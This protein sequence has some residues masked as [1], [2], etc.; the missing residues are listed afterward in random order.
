MRV[1]VRVRVCLCVCMCLHSYL[2]VCVC[3]RARVCARACIWC[4]CL[5]VGMR[6]CACACAYSCV[7]V[8]VRVWVCC[9]SHGMWVQLDARALIFVFSFLT[10][11]WVH[12]HSC[13][14]PAII[15]LPVLSP[16][17]RG[18][19]CA[20]KLPDSKTSWQL[21]WIA[22]PTLPY[23]LMPILQTGGR[24]DGESFH[25]LSPLGERDIIVCSTNV[26]AW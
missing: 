14:G 9:L 4:V 10:C 8:R 1:R 21:S 20:G 24:I 12:V 15:L 18:A 19:H 22:Q 13:A 16:L 5:C 11:L 2:R 3:V 6:I 7:Q 17:T 25:F 23:F 26:P